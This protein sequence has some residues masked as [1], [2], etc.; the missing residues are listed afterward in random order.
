MSRDIIEAVA[1]LN[2]IPDLLLSIKRKHFFNKYTRTVLFINCVPVLLWL[3]KVVYAAENPLD[4][5]FM[6]NEKD[7]TRWLTRRPCKLEDHCL[8]LATHAISTNAS[9]GLSFCVSR[10]GVERSHR[11]RKSPV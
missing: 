2:L 3:I 1:V 11:G 6:R 10:R 4:A 8:S 9:K 5:L 7:V